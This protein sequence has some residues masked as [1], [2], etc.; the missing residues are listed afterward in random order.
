MLITLHGQIFRDGNHYI[1]RC[2]ELSIATAGDTVDDALRRTRDMIEGYF[3]A[4]SKAGTLDQ[5]LAKIVPGE[6]KVNLKD[7]EFTTD[8]HI[9]QD[10][11]IAL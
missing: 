1:S 11:R 2:H 8:F 7:L 4:C 3:A 9:Q 6:T 10:F 5:I